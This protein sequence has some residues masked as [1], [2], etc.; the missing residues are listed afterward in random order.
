MLSEPA[1]TSVD[2]DD[3]SS[4]IAMDKKALRKA[5]KKL[6]KAERRAQREGRGDPL[7]GQKIC[8]MCNASVNLLVRCTYDESQQWKMVCG[9]CW[10]VASGG[11]VDGDSTHP[12]Y[13]YGGLWKNRRAQPN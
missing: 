2:V 5:N 12:F 7:A 6:M 4:N 11:V 10:K 3:T 8:D 13:K 1:T 9:K